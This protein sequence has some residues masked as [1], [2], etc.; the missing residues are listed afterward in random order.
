MTRQL[1]TERITTITV[2]YCSEADNKTKHIIT[3]WSASDLEER[4]LRVF[5]NRVL[6][7]KF[8]PKRDEVTVEWRKLRNEELNELYSLS[9]IIRVMI[10]RR[11]RRAGHAAR[12]GKRRDVYRVLVGKPE[13]K[14]HL[15]GP[16]VYGRIILRWIFRKWDVGY[17]LD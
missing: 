3:F 4:R 14:K 1:G 7:R 2:G 13:G 8:N 15:E 6:K 12:M 9:N 11:M 17:G 16:G 5:K 10:L